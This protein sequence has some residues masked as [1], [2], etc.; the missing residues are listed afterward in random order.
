MYLTGTLHPTCSSFKDE[1]KYSHLHLWGQVGVQ[2]QNLQISAAARR[3]LTDA[4]VHLFYTLVNFVLTSH[5][6]EDVPWGRP[7]V[8]IDA[9]IY[10]LLYGK[11]A[12]LACDESWLFK[13]LTLNVLGD[14]RG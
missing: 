11:S 4:F 8:E 5:E 2:W 13:E 10:H 9:D 7:T 12:V 1:P 3:H 14:V 6:D